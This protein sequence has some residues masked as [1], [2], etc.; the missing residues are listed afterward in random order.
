MVAAGAALLGSGASLA[1]G[2]AVDD[3]L[4][5]AA[6]EA[7]RQRDRADLAAL[8]ERAQ[9]EQH[10]LSSWVDYWAL[11]SRLPSA[12]T[13]DVQA[14]YRRW[15]G[16]YVEDRLRN[17]W[18]LE[19]GK[20]RDWSAFAVDYPR[21]RMDDDREV[22][23]MAGLAEHALGQGP[24]KPSNEPFK[25]R[26]LAAWL[27]QREP[28]EACTLLGQTLSDGAKPVFG[29]Q[30]HW[31]KLRSSV[32]ANRLATFKRTANLTGRHQ[33]A[34]L[35]RA[36]DDPTRFLLRQ[37]KSQSRGE[38]EQAAV[39]LVRLAAS[40]T[41]RTD[42]ATLD[43]TSNTHTSTPSTHPASNSKANKQHSKQQSTPLHSHYHD[44]GT[45]PRLQP[46]IDDSSIIESGV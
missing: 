11:F 21:F 5:A 37:A 8:S 46:I 20:R 41:D 17:D 34:G 12:T 18:L 39:A 44:T 36:F 35:V 15:P 7:W 22:H 13:A 16:S 42:T 26:A 9:A 3:P 24:F 30:E 43:P 4:M 14:F 32:E 1:Q 31:A 25:A 33:E 27:A 29:R 28:T 19:L 2:M 6:R 23:C 40:D 38:L 45:N 10:V